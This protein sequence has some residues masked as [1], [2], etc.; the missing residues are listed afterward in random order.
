MKKHHFVITGGHHN[1]ALVVARSLV[2]LGHKVT[3][4]GHKTA[5]KGDKHN[6]AEYL[7][8]NSSGI[9]FHDLPAGKISLHS[10]FSSAFKIPLGLTK[11]YSLVRKLKP[12]AVLSFGGYLGLS[13][14][15]IARAKNIPVFLH[16]QTVI[17]GKANKLVAKFAKR[18]YL[19]WESSLKFFPRGNTLV[20]GLPLR[21]SILNPKKTKLFTN[22]LPTL[23]VLGG[24]QGSHLI[25]QQIFQNLQKLLTHYNLIHQTGTSSVTGDYDRAVGIKNSLPDQLGDRYRPEGYITEAEIGSILGNCDLYIGRSG[26]HITYELGM[27]GVRSVLIPYLHT[28][29]LEQ[30]KNA[31]YLA[32]ND[33]A[34]ILPQHKLNYSLLKQGIIDAQKLSPKPLPLPRDAANKL[35]KDL[36]DEVSL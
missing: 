7:E 24:K 1:S 13:V 14:A 16:E 23:L 10:G 3:W 32:Q 20:T 27:L 28:H 12:D 21:S 15:L 11:A 36:V 33:I 30:K 8:V 35:V 6:S 18:V 22:S 17:A 29:G 31:E 2:E 34:I 25:N 5:S 19:T 26:A 4:I 9:P